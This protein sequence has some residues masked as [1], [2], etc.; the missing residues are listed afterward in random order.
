MRLTIDN[1]DGL[2][3]VDYSAAIDRAEPLE[4]ARTLNAPSIASGLLT[5]AGTALKTPVRRARI[6]LASD[7]GTLLFTGYLTTEPMPIYAGCATEG[8]VYRLAFRAVSDEWLLDKSAGGAGASVYGQPAGTALLGLVATLAPGVFTTTGILQ[9]QKL[10]VLAPAVGAAF[11]AQAGAAAGAAYSAYRV[12]NGGL[13]L[14]QAGSTTHTFSEGDGSLT[15]AAL[16][17]ASVRELANDV[18]LTGA[19]EPAAYWQEFFLGDGATATFPLTGQPAAVRNG[20]AVLIADDFSSGALNHRTWTA[21]DPGSHLA[22]GAAG[23]LIDGGNG[24]DGQTTLFA[25]ADV[26][27]GGTLVF[28]L[29]GV[30]LNTASAGV[31]ATSRRRTC[32]PASTCASQAATRS[33]RR[34][35]TAR[36]RGA[37]SRSYKARRIRCVCACIVRSCC[38]RARLF[39]RWSTQPA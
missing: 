32:L 16:R 17:T 5:L 9:G 39:M 30:L 33:L 34:W 24:F 14:T 36:K 6:V 20:H 3:A 13:T 23:F 25:N 27:L 1:L 31:L 18:T 15:L 29:A 22:F 2:G 28:E 7:S 10:G 19:E 38:G 4:I 26:E 37:R 12:L 35:S 8:A 21:S 11:S